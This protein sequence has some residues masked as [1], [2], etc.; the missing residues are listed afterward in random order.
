MSEEKHQKDI[1]V[2]IINCKEAE[3]ENGI[4]KYTVSTGIG[5]ASTA[6]LY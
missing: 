2:H 6:Y 3:T 1:R 4:G 5:I